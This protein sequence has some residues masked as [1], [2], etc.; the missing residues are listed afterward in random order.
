MIWINYLIR[1]PIGAV[2]GTILIAI[3]A[4]AIIFMAI[5]VNWNNQIGELASL[6]SDWLSVVKTIGG[7]KES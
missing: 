6:P 4:V 1:V 3:A 2:I 5:C 7:I